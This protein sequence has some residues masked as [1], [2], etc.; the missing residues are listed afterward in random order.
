MAT[1]QNA[2]EIYIVT[3]YGCNSGVGNLYSPTV[4]VFSKKEDAM[5]YFRSIAFTIRQ[6]PLKWD[7]P[8][9][10]CQ[11]GDEYEGGCKCPEG[12][13]LEGGRI[14]TMTQEERLGL[15]EE[16]DKDEASIECIC[17][18]RY[19]KEDEAAHVASTHHTFYV[20]YLLPQEDAQ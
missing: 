5:E 1:E 3:R 9:D 12:V 11:R 15:Q 2:P 7:R 20:T 4:T 17:G 19:H 10:V 18:K 14:Q 16:N 8:F 13:K 6:K